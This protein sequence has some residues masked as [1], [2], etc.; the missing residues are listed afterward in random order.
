MHCILYLA[1]AS[2]DEILQK[3]SFFRSQLFAN[4]FYDKIPFLKIFSFKEKFFRVSTMAARGF[5]GNG[6]ECLSWPKNL[7]SKL[8]FQ[9]F[10][11]ISIQIRF[12]HDTFKFVSY[13]IN[14]PLSNS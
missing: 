14:L 12:S 2:N 1:I 7:T 6:Y 3:K 10:A 13:P 8:V 5:Q 9:L 11:I 4:Q